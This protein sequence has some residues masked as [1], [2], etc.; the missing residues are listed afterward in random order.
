MEVPL[1]PVRPLVQVLPQLPGI[2]IN[3]METV[4]LLQPKVAAPTMRQIFPQVNVSCV[5]VDLFYFLLGVGL[6]LF[7]K[8]C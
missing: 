8:F 2:V 1:L 4:P 6:G 3:N 5:F 7:L